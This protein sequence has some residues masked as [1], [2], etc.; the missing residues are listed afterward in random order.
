MFTRRYWMVFSAVAGA[1]LFISFRPRAVAAATPPR[2]AAAYPDGLALTPPLGWNSY[3]SFGGA[4]NESQFRNNVRYVADHLARYGWK[5]VVVDYY[6][7]FAESGVEH[8]T[9]NEDKI[10]TA[11]D[12]YGR[13]LP[14]PQRFPSAAGGSGFKPL[15]D[16]AH[17][18]GL[19]FGIHIMRGI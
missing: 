1:A 5:Y 12:E 19:K 9:S 16:Y 13:L 2:G 3:D 7:Y 11:M 4:V 15:A 8:G 18:L 17:S 14:D 10:P 6:W